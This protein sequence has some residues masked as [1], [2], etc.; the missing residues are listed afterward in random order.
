VFGSCAR[1]MMSAVSASRLVHVAISH[2]VPIPAYTCLKSY[3]GRFTRTCI[4]FY[5]L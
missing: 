3:F 5:Y 4:I 2:P 1:A